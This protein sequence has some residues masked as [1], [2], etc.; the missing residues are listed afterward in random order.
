LNKLLQVLETEG[1]FSHLLDR[2]ERMYQFRKNE[3]VIGVRR[4]G[5]DLHFDCRRRDVPM[6]NTVMY[7]VIAELE[8]TVR[9]LR[10]PVDA[11]AIVRQLQETVPEAAHHAALSAYISE[12]TLVPRLAAD[13]K[14]GV[15]DE[16]LDALDGQGLIRNLKLA[17]EAVLSR[18]E[19]MSTGM[20][21]GI[22]IPHGR[23]DAVKRLVCA[24]GLKPEG[25]DFGAIDGEPSR[26]FV[27]TLSPRSVSAPHMQFMSMVSQVLDDEGREALLACRTADA[28]CA[29]LCGTEGGEESVLS[30][31]IRQ[32]GAL[33]R[34]LAG[35]LAG[36]AGPKQEALTRYLRPELMEVRLKGKTRTEVIDELLAILSRQGLVN[37]VESVRDSVL[38]RED[39]LPTALGHGVAIPHARTDAVDA[40]V[41]AV[42]IKQEGVDFDAPDG[43]PATI[44]LLTLSPASGPAPHIQFMAMIS[45][46][47]DA[48]GRA[49]ALA[50]ESS[51][52]LWRVLVREA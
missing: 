5:R 36:P 10:K 22:A 34:R 43:D 38:A 49:K 6:L 19:S 21:H 30:K 40:L 20:Q 15:I 32:A 28:M 12:E 46:T 47:L 39:D 50:A 24:V 41:C 13:T 51:E 33:A 48:D 35:R 17:R 7:E 45:R 4:R 8:R 14:E 3:T 37:D 25:I 31:G 29:A 11:K 27:L 26:I 16:L 23:T 52:A 42:G 9:E 44:I 2:A 18:E 1:F